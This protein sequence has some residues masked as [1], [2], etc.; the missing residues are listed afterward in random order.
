MNK[1]TSDEYSIEHSNKLLINIVKTILT[2]WNLQIPLSERTKTKKKVL[3]KKL[4]N[5]L[6][7]CIHI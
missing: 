6:K 1:N 4:E 3:W 5:M 7:V 2:L